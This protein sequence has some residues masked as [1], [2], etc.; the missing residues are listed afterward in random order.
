MVA[1][2]A[3]CQA[4]GIP[5]EVNVAGSFSAQ[6]Q[7]LFPAVQ[8]SGASIA[9]SWPSRVWDDGRGFFSAHVCETE[10]RGKDRAVA[11]VGVYRARLANDVSEVVAEAIATYW[12][13][14]DVE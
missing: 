8:K 1:N 3:L 2:S 14:D 13:L 11:V 7:Y 5:E 9:V 6:V 4:A 10:K 12:G